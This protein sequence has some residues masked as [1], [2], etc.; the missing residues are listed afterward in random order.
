MLVVV[1]LVVVVVVVV[2]VVEVLTVVRV[3]TT[4]LAEDARVNAVVV[5]GVD[6]VQ[7]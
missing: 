5:V 2:V 6:D 7:L 4:G 1:A 3:E